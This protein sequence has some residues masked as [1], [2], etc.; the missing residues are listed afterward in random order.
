MLEED[1]IVVIADVPSETRITKFCLA[2]VP[3]EN[4]APSI[5]EPEGLIFSVLV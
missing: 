2:G 3:S 1:G 4:P 5:S